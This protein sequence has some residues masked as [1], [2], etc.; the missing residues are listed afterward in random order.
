MTKPIFLVICLLVLSVNLYAIDTFQLKQI[1]PRSQWSEYSPDK[2]HRAVIMDDEGNTFVA[3]QKL[4]PLHIILQK[5]DPEGN[6]IWADP[7]SGLALVDTMIGY[8]AAFAPALASDGHGG[9]FVFYA[10]GKSSYY[11]GEFY[12]SF[13][14][15]LQHLNENG[16]KSWGNRGI[17]IHDS[18]YSYVRD[19]APDGKGGVYL[20]YTISSDNSCIYGGTSLQHV[21]NTG[22]LL[23]SKPGKV[24]MPCDSSSVTNL[25]SDGLNGSYIY[26]NGSYLQQIDINGEFIFPELFIDMGIY[27]RRKW[28]F[29]VNDGLIFVGNESTRNP[30][31]LKIQK[32]DK[33]GNLLL[34]ANGASYTWPD[35]IDFYPV[36]TLKNDSSL[37][38]FS[39]IYGQNI[40]FDDEIHFNAPNKVIQFDQL[41]PWNIFATYSRKFGNLILYVAEDF[42]KG[43]DILKLQKI[44]D[45][46]QIPWG[47]DGVTICE[48]NDFLLFT[49]SIIQINEDAGKAIIFLEL[50]EGIHIATVDLETGTWIAEQ[51][52]N[53]HIVPVTYNISSYPNPFTNLIQIDIQPFKT[54]NDIKSVKIF[55]ILGKEVKD[56]TPKQISTHTFSWDGTD[57]SGQRAA[58]GIYFVQITAKQTFT[59]KIL[60]L[61]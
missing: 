18:T 29:P 58:A 57:D 4:G 44:D 40:Y 39:G 8:D 23:F 30:R 16:V 37:S 5:L 12:H 53:N 46:G 19:I 48:T 31:K 28:L 2:P 34:G 54:T 49:H 3:S 42:T 51:Q 41:Q 33:Q 11:E 20:M 9:L 22:T 6:P 56:I 27:L 43:R 1:L 52:E 15:Y 55:N 13:T 17:S 10:Y 25:T 45:N 26:N 24:L 7:N 35:S 38:V 50:G 60:K 59:Q 32:I 61:K 36:I 47:I 14:T 21:D